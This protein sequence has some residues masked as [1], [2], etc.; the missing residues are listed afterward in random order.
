MKIVEAMLADGHEV[1]TAMLA[2]PKVS[3]LEGSAHPAEEVFSRD[4]AWIEGADAMVAEVSTPSHGVGFEVGY[5]LNL[6]KPVLALHH[7]SRLVSKMILGNKATS[8][9]IVNYI[10]DDEAIAVVQSFLNSI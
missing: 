6:G 9:R 4:V 3:R 8:L 7:Q 2:G 1:P 10:S 5:A